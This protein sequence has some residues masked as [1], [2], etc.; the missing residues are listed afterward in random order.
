MNA[1][2][3]RRDGASSLSAWFRQRRFPAEF[4]ILPPAEGAHGV[5]GAA[6]PP[7]A[8]PSPTASGPTAPPVPDGLPDDQPNDLPGALP[9]DLPDDLPDEV[10]A[11][12]VTEIWRAR[13]KVGGPTADQDAAR[14]VRWAN[15][16]LGAAADR[17]ARAG[18]E[19]H[20]HDGLRFDVGMDLRVLAYQDDPSVTEETV[21]ETVRP[22]VRR[23]GRVIQ[24]GEVIVAVPEKAAPENAV[25]EH[26]APE[27]AASE[28]RGHDDA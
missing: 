3:R 15:R 21:V 25:P 10:V 16:Y 1:A 19:A 13:N 11:D 8:E 24:E 7:S 27:K 20:G 23:A 6:A 2:P 22:S 14:A 26:A 5:P 12:L 28:T 18:I 4:R 17:L 9:D